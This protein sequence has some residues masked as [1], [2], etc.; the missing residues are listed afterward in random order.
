MVPRKALR[1]TVLDRPRSQRQALPSDQQSA[2]V[3][4]V[5]TA[6]PYRRRGIV[7]SPP[8]RFFSPFSRVSRRLPRCPGQ[9]PGPK[10]VTNAFR[11]LTRTTSVPATA[12]TSSPSADTPP[13]STP[14]SSLFGLPSRPAPL[15]CVSSLSLFLLCSI[16]CP[17]INELLLIV[18]TGFRGGKSV[19][20]VVWQPPDPRVM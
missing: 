3:L 2:I 13:P 14:G 7:F 11:V 6:R 10:M 9:G 19:L 4:L 20:G 17:G 8:L 16:N 15:V 12:E 5:S 18:F 1:P